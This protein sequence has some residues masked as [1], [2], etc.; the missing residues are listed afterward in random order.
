VHQ[1][2]FVKRPIRNELLTIFVQVLGNVFWLFFYWRRIMTYDPESSGQTQLRRTE[3]SVTF[4]AMTKKFFWL[5]VVTVSTSKCFHMERKLCLTAMLYSASDTRNSMVWIHAQ[6][7]ARPAFLS[8]RKMKEK[9]YAWRSSRK[10]R[11]AKTNPDIAQTTSVP[12]PGGRGK[13]I[14][15]TSIIISIIKW[16]RYERKDSS[17]KTSQ[18]FLSSLKTF[19]PHSK[20][21]ESIELSSRIYPGK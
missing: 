8:F 20:R 2:S 1:N 9:L 6:N 12:F 19:Y 5:Q 4:V 16:H 7:H 18:N 11:S 10:S 17:L 3:G 13:N 14:I 15:N 21:L